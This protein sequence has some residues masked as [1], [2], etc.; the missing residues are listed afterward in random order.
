MDLLKLMIGQWLRLKKIKKDKEKE[1]KDDWK[2]EDDDN[3]FYSLD[4]EE[5]EEIEER[6][7]GE[8][9]VT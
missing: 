1:E 8:N 4:H 2:R 6:A 3:T 7:T 5:S 9:N